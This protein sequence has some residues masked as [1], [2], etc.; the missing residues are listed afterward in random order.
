MRT[1][2]LVET[3]DL[4]TRY[5]A[6]AARSLGYEPVFLCDPNEYAGDVRA[7][8]LEQRIRVVDSSSVQA[9]VEVVARESAQGEAAILSFVDARLEVACLA[10]VELGLP[11]LDPAVVELKSKARV[12]ALLPEH[13]PPTLAFSVDR[14]PMRALER[15]LSEHGRLVVKPS[16]G[17]GG[18]GVFFVD[19]LAM[20]RRLAARLES[21]S[22]PMSMNRSEFVAQAYV[23]GEVSSLEGYALEGFFHPLGYT[24]RKKIGLTECGSEHPV[25]ARIP[26]EADRAMKAAATALV[27]RSGMRSGYLHVEFILGE[28]GP[29]LID[30][31]AGRLGGGPI[32]ELLAFAHGVEPEAIYRHAIEVALSGPES[33][34]PYRRPED[35]QLASAVLY[36]LERGGRLLAL[37]LPELG[38]ARHTAV[39]GSGDEV[40]AMGSGDW[41]W[42][43]IVTGQ[44]RAVAAALAGLRIHTTVGVE[45]PCY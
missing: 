6:R 9:I 45:S 33:E 11:G 30:A 17:A 18:A 15:L 7:Q 8:L 28:D 38:A 35:R 13:T 44:Q 36:G 22:L 27:E 39:L 12:A 20:L 3:T 32:G 42:V 41:A 37:D 31:N 23:K 14:L 43:G 26:F 21:L 25:D 10:A 40:A 29:V 24:D 5:C 34:H 19:D 16:H 2:Y 1:L 4:G